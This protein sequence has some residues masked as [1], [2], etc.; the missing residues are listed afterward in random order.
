MSLNYLVVCGNDREASWLE[1]S[2]INNRTLSGSE[3]A[4]PQSQASLLSDDEY[5]LSPA[6]I[7][8]CWLW[9]VFWLQGRILI[10]L[11]QDF[12]ALYN[13]AIA[14]QS[15]GCC[16][17]EYRYPTCSFDTTGDLG[18]RVNMEA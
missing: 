2:T 10:K 17:Q 12:P 14:Q 3:K 4:F 11:E 7:F 9:W 8:F 13:V 5:G 6:V 1:T 16:V 15:E 18:L